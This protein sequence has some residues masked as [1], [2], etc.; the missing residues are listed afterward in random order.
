MLEA[1][2]VRGSR[3]PT[4][5]FGLLSAGARA[6]ETGAAECEHGDEHQGFRW[7]AKAPSDNAA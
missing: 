7:L 4:Q 2:S 6:C 5:V 1:V 3:R